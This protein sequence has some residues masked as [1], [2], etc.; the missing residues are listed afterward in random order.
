[1]QGAGFQTSLPLGRA[2]EGRG[3]IV[4][5]LRCD[6]VGGWPWGFF[7]PRSSMGSLRFGPQSTQSQLFWLC[8][9]A[10]PV[11][12]AP[13]CPPSCFNPSFSSPGHWPA[14]WLCQDGMLTRPSCALT[15]L[16]HTLL[17]REMKLFCFLLLVLNCQKSFNI[18]SFFAGRKPSR[19]IVQ[20][21]EI[22]ETLIPLCSN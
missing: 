4:L 6:S 1:M 3:V 16:K 9:R 8:Q 19:C 11:P 12:G 5:F 17:I 15:P 13:P 7:Q 18:W 2:T 20:L 22:G 10:N 14:C 21:R